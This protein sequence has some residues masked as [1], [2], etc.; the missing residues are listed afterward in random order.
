MHFMCVWTK[1]MLKIQH[2][3][4]PPAGYFLLYIQLQVTYSFLPWDGTLPIHQVHGPIWILSGNS[5]KSLWFTWHAKHQLPTRVWF[6]L[7][8]LTTVSFKKHWTWSCCRWQ[9]LTKGWSFLQ[10]LRS[11]DSLLRAMPDIA[12]HQRPPVEKQP[13]NKLIKCESLTGG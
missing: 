13:Q 3:R 7:E 11:W 1:F 9:M 8:T 10:A 4:R 5:N 2:L 6:V 12:A